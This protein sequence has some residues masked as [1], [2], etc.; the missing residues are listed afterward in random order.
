MKSLAEL[1]TDEIKYTNEM[2]RDLHIKNECVE[3]LMNLIIEMAK[4]CPHNIV[5]HASKEMQKV[6]DKYCGIKE[7]QIQ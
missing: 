5:D 3:D 2:Q 7:Y 4:F 1:I 6:T